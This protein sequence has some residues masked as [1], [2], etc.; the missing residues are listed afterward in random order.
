MYGIQDHETGHVGPF[1]KGQMFGSVE[2][3]LFILSI[4]GFMFSTGALDLG[5]HHLSSRF[6]ERGPLLIAVRIVLFGLLGSIKGWSDETL[7]LYA[8]MV[9]L[10]IA[11]GY[12]RM[13]TVAVVTVAPLV[14]ALAS[15]INP[16]L[17]D[18]VL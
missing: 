7:G 5:I 17:S 10:M 3:F 1:N 13:V 15:T 4:G 16:I 8:M 9:P 18:C 2:V 11:L 12:D 6:R 14:G